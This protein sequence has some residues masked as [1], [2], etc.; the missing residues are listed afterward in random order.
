MDRF[1]S[2]GWR[3][4]IK[5]PLGS[6]GAAEVYLARDLLQ[7]R[8]VAVKYAKREARSGIKQ[9][10]I[11]LFRLHHGSLVTVHEYH[12]AGDGEF[13]TMEHCRG[14]PVNRAFQGVPDSDKPRRLLEIWGALAEVL[15]YLHAR[16]IIHGDLK[17]ENILLDDQGIKIIDLGFAVRRPRG[18]RGQFRGTLAYGAPEVVS[19]EDDPSVAADIYSL[20]LIL[21][22]L[23]AGRLPSYELRLSPQGNWNIQ[24]RELLPLDLA[25]VLISMVKYDPLERPA[26]TGRLLL[27]LAATGKIQPRERVHGLKF[28]GR[29]RELARLIAAVPPRTTGVTCIAG[30]AGSGKSRLLAE[31]N[32]LHQVN[33]RESHL[34]TAPLQEGTA[35]QV[36]PGAA[37]FVD[38][39]G[40]RSCQ[41]LRDAGRQL[42][43]IS[44]TEPADGDGRDDQARLVPLAPLAIEAYPVF[45]GEIFPGMD[46]A[47]LRR[48]ARHLAE[49][50]GGDLRYALLS[51]NG[52]LERAHLSR[53]RNAW[54]VDWLRLWDDTARPAAVER[55]LTERWRALS[56]EQRARLR[57]LAAGRAAPGATAPEFWTTEQGLRSGLMER[58]VLERSLE[59]DREALRREL[60]LCGAQPRG[61]SIEQ[62]RMMAECS[63]PEEWAAAA[64]ARF[65]AAR[66]DA[67]DEAAMYFGQKLVDAQS[68]GIAQRLG[69]AEQLVGLY[70]FHRRH[71]R[72]AAVLKGLRDHLRW[73]HYEMWARTY[74]YPLY[75][76]DR[77][78]IAAVIA[79]GRKTIAADDA[80][81]RTRAAI[82]EGLI[83]ALRGDGAAGKAA[84][85]SAIAAADGTAPD[86][87]LGN[88]FLGVIELGEGDTQQARRHCLTAL[89]QIDHRADPLMFLQANTLIG[90]I[91][92]KRGEHEGANGVYVNCI[93]A[94]Q[95]VVPEETLTPV[96]IAL[97]CLYVRLC[98]HGRAMEYLSRAWQYAGGSTD[99]TDRALIL[100]NMAIIHAANGQYHLALEMYDEAARILLEIGNRVGYLQA[101]CNMSAAENALGK[102]RK[103]FRLLEKGL[104]IARELRDEA[105]EAMVLKNIGFFENDHDDYRGSLAHLRQ[106]V[107]LY[108][109]LGLEI[110]RYIIET[111]ILNALLIKDRAETEHWE[112]L[113]KK[114]PPITAFDQ[115]GLRYIEGLR[116]IRDG[117]A[118]QGLRAAFEAGKEMK[119]KG[120]GSGAAFIWLRSAEM[121]LREEQPSVLPGVIQSLATAAH[122]FEQLGESSSLAKA[123]RLLTEA[124]AALSRSPNAYLSY[125]MLHGLY[126]LCS[127]IGGLDEPTAVAGAALDLVMELLG[128]ERGGIFLKDA[129]GTLTL[130]AQ[131]ELDSE[132]T[133]DAYEYS[134]HTLQQALEGESVIY[135][136][137]TELDEAFRSRLSI[138]TNRIRSLLCAPIVFREGALGAIYLD[139]RLRTNLFDAAQRRFLKAMID[140]LGAVLEGSQLLRRLDRENRSLRQAAPSAL[141]GIIGESPEMAALIGQVR[142]IAPVDIS[143]LITGETGTGKELIARSIHELSPRR[144]KAFVAIDCGALPETLLE[145]ELFGYAKGA[146]TDAKAAKAGLFETAEGGTIFLDEVNSA[147]KAVQARLLRVIET[148]KLRRVG[149]TGERQVDVRLIC[150]SNAD[151]DGEIE[152]GAFRSD[153]FYRI[154]EVRLRL[155][156]LRERRKDIPVLAEYF[157]RRYM[158]QFGRKRLRFSAAAL[159]TMLEYPWPGNVRE[160]EHV[161]KSAVLLTTGSDIHPKDLG[162]PV[163]AGQA[164]ASGKA[165]REEREKR[166]II[167][168]LKETRGN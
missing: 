123:Q 144:G 64:T 35:A 41:W 166:E 152:S 161:V 56:E 45:L 53:Q 38:R 78:E 49:R 73:R 92:V 105:L 3:Y 15:G 13:F 54:R 12:Q 61:C 32:F 95:G 125:P 80:P 79:A 51:L 28:A 6:G 157:K 74:I 140:I 84:I 114:Y 159:R 59:R 19:G 102:E 98:D 18:D 158:E 116:Q 44:V 22:E 149:E 39:A 7:D 24:A 165:M 136:N 120:D 124:E 25:E 69:V 26:P 153:L 111:G 113:L 81:A 52:W 89:D 163:A 138:R 119:R 104:A 107:A 96:Y 88:Y 11:R 154:K 48:L 5:Q 40:D 55:E 4:E 109:K 167:D 164:P 129:N 42:S 93:E 156:P 14:V 85:R 108:Q 77:E 82:W 128:V 145:A 151:L 126:R 23:V 147:S 94:L 101:L 20:G 67:D 142:T 16:G 121:A 60:R 31:L 30:P 90:G 65:E 146:F 34:V 133:R 46:A 103:A 148:G 110:N 58:F 2:L 8:D 150:A 139:S 162:L 122:E 134:L 17:P 141:S 99:A 155:P 97:A 75:A 91:D 127:A 43:V 71:E 72:A 130:A 117:A 10:F 100:T 132:T 160:L 76:K 9:E 131:A 70:V 47:T 135:A 27:A 115:V 50:T 63:L 168:A 66:R 21:F 112:A 1:P 36:P 57:Q 86:R 83:A 62:W 68:V 87:A 143:V 106:S 29:S 118:D 37:L 33:G 137:D